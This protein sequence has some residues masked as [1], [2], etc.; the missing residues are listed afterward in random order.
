LDDLIIKVS[1]QMRQRDSVVSE[2]LR[3]LSSF[4]TQQDA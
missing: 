4:Q 2:Q 1:N 3:D